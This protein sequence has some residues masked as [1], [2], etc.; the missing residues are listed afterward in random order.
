MVWLVNAQKY[1]LKSLLVIIHSILQS[2]DEIDSCCSIEPRR[3]FIQ[4]KK[5]RPDA[6]LHGNC[7]PAF[8]TSRQTTLD[9]GTNNGVLHMIEPK[10]LQ[11]VPCKL[12]SFMLVKTC[13]HPYGIK[14]CLKTG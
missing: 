2:L 13:S 9:D 10:L 5:V 4:K 8:F 12:Q 3:G 7:E 1:T 11:S 14:K 6:E